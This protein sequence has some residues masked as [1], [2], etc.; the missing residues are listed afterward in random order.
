MIQTRSR[1]TVSVIF[2]E[3]NEAERHFLDKFV[4]AGKLPN[5]ARALGSG[6]IVRT[7]IPS[8]DPSEDKAWRK[9]SPWIVWP[10]MYTGLAPEEHGLVGFGQDPAAIRGKCVWDVLDAHGIPVGV[11]GS[12]MSYP[13]RTSGAAAFYVPESLADTAECFPDEAR[14]LQEFCVF[15]ARNYSESFGKSAVTAIKLL[16]R[17][18]KSGVSA[19]TV[20]RTLRQVPIEALRGAPVAP[21]RA[22][23][24]SYMTRDAFLKL[25]AGTRPA[26]ASVHMNHIAY[27][28]HRY[29]RAAEPERFENDLSP[30]DRRFFKS[31]GERKGYEGKLA[32]WIETSF[33]YADKFLGELLE[34]ADE[35][36]VVLVG[37]ALGQRPFDPVTDIHNP[38]VRLVEERALFD[39]V[40][41]RDY[42]VLHQMN[43][44]LTINLADEAAARAAAE[45]LGGFYVEGHGGLFTVQRRGQQ[46]FCELDMPRRA[47]D[48]ETFTIRHRALDGFRADFAR[49]IREHGTADQSTAHHKDSGW[50]LACRR[51]GRV[52]AT[53][54]VVSVT[55][56]A[57]TILSLFGLPP[58]PWMDAN[59]KAFLAL[60]G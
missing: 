53:H 25:Y 54:D 20:L 41:M 10:S 5:F 19:G 28:Q 52:R 43:P 33:V 55:D 22:M 16:L 37:T 6:A 18:P 30:T 35:R 17:T 27:M 12:L 15:A 13:P 4:A 24:H 7:R 56:V 8:W 60:D 14:A 26:Y 32:H 2:F 23:L 1:P 49:H 46:V 29:W 44:D 34:I 31:V 51:S 42:E 36:T 57:P 21:E 45:K 9:I 50:L 58:S 38:V 39:G 40:G 59:A 47:K 11:L 3:L 48:G